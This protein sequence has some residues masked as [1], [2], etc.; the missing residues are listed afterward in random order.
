[1]LLLHGKNRRSTLIGSHNCCGIGGDSCWLNGTFG[2]MVYL[3]GFDD[4][5]LV[6]ESLR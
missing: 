1:M 6:N 5:R 3:S 4:K 2:G